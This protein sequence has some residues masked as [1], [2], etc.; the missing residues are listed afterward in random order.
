MTAG[1]HVPGRSVRKRGPGGPHGARRPDRRRAGGS[2]G[3]R[4]AH[5]AVI[6]RDLDAGEAAC[7]RCLGLPSSGREDLPG[8]GV[9]VSFIPVG[10]A[11]VELLEPAD[12][13]GALGKF[14]A[15]RGPGVHHLALEVQDLAAA[16]ARARAAGL[17]L[18]DPAP[19][20]GAHGTRVAFIH[21]ACTHGVLVELVER[22]TGGP[23]GCVP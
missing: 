3:A 19:R 22:G 11:R 6:V 12:P 9:R 15:A 23:S 5:L 17:R 8:E 7:S 21:P 4:L 10:T 20:T 2:P 13:H 1:A 16:M 18:I 14:L